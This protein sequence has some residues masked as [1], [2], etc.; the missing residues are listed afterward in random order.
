EAAGYYGRAWAH[1]K[2]R[3]GTPYL[4][5]MMLILGSAPLLAAT[6]YMTLGRLARNIDAEAYC[7]MRSTWISKIHIIID[8]ANFGCTRRIIGGVIWGNVIVGT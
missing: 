8:I 3:N 2:I 7:L 4:I 5:Q 6:V 1:D